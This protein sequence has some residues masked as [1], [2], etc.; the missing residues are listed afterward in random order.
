MRIL[1]FHIVLSLAIVAGF[2]GLGPRAA[3]AV[4]KDSDSLLE[5]TIDGAADLKSA[6]PLVLYV[7]VKNLTSKSQSFLRPVLDDWRTM[8][9]HMRFPGSGKKLSLEQTKFDDVAERGLRANLSL[10]A[11]VLPPG[12]NYTFSIYLSHGAF[13]GSGS[14]P[15]YL[16]STEGQY[17]IYV[18]VFQLRDDVQIVKGLVPHTSERIAIE[19][20]VEIAA[21]M[22]TD[23]VDS[24]A[25]KDLLECPSLMFIHNP[26]LIGRDLP[27][28]ITDFVHEHSESKFAQFILPAELQSQFWQGM[29]S[30]KVEASIAVLNKMVS[31]ASNE[32]TDDWPPGWQYQLDQVLAFFTSK[33]S[34]ICHFDSQS[35][36]PVL[37][38]APPAISIEV[39]KVIDTLAT[40][41][42]DSQ[43]DKSLDLFAS[44]V[45]YRGHIID[46]SAL[47]SLLASWIARIRDSDEVNKSDLQVQV[48]SPTGNEQMQAVKVSF[49]IVTDTDRIEAGEAT[50]RLFRIGDEWIIYGIDP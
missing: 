15:V 36:N 35:A 13:E 46:R 19:D 18:G 23:V 37:S 3:C 2:I 11:V 31:L 5:V 33:L 20:S 30:K 28:S 50:F 7:T 42:S 12:G 8:S 6:D 10:G 43:L 9:L 47:T 38:T 22:P 32:Q 16:F 40:Q 48:S 29:S 14:R 26:T 39:E 1:Q 17:R 45:A 4:L 44:N 25:A 49:Y 21:S 34:V 27:Q 24:S 41:L